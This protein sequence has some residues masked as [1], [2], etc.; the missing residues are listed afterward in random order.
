MMK[1]FAL[2]VA[3]CAVAHS[4]VAAD[5]VEFKMSGELR[6]RYE[7]WMTPTASSSNA[8]SLSGVKGRARL[9]VTARRGERLQMMIS[10]LHGSQFGSS[11]AN[12]TD[13]TSAAYASTDQNQLAVARAWGWW[14]AGDNLTFKVGRM[15]VEIGDGL[16]F[17]ENDWEQT[18]TMLEGLT[19]VYDMDFARLSIYA[20]K[21]AKF[22]RVNGTAQ[23][24]TSGAPSWDP[25]QNIYM[26]S[27]DFKNLPEVLRMA[28]VHIAQISRDQTTVTSGNADL[29]GSGAAAGAALNAQRVGA[30]VAGE[31][32]GFTYNLTGA[33]VFGN[34]KTTGTNLGLAGDTSFA[35]NQNMVDVALGYRLP[36][37][38]GLKFG[39][40][41]HR[42]S[43]SN[44]V[45]SSTNATGDTT[46]SGYDPLFYARHG[47]SGLMDVV[48]FGNLSFYKASFAMTP[49]EDLEAGVAYYVFSRTEKGANSSRNVFGA[50]YFSL[51]GSPESGD[52]GSE[53]DVFVNKSYD[54]NFRIGAH[55]GMFMPDAYLKSATGMYASGRQDQTIMQA[56][57]QATMAF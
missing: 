15:G 34:A 54:G 20:L 57:L 31:T 21:T 48:R 16:V 18:P 7:N 24:S 35:L 43:G 55:W 22:N 6:T 33:Y 50:N 39:I 40:G 49:I 37:V 38:M 19:A 4:A 41:Y 44:N 32:K 52:I 5:E 51:Q 8:G 26:L 12:N 13:T 28:N 17:S 29:M 53:L 45:R 27:F 46:L 56:M 47:S 10:L 36:E 42:D 1:R 9:G 23:G 14:K 11:A 3:A 30:T 2:A 25:E